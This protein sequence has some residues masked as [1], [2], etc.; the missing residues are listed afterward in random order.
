[1]ILS[2]QFSPSRP[3][4]ESKF[5]WTHGS[6][7]S[8]SELYHTGASPGSM[9]SADLPL[10]S[11]VPGSTQH[12]GGKGRSSGITLSDSFSLS[13]CL[14]TLSTHNK[15]KLPFSVFILFSFVCVCGRGD[16][17]RG[18]F[19]MKLKLLYILTPTGPFQGPLPYFAFI[20]FF[21]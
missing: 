2:I 5:G 10:V 8:W 1:M 21:S 20:I 13:C 15:T 19:T 17:Y 18:G 14:L 7:G 3:W 11:Q 12:H 6:R 4:F 16:Y 9:T